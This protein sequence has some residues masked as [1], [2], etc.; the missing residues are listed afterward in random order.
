[1]RAMDINCDM[2]ESFGIYKLG[3]DEHI[4]KYISSANIACGYH[5]GDP[6]T[7]RKT[8]SLCLRNGVA[9]GAHPGF[10]DRE[11]F[12]RR[13]IHMSAQE[14]YDAVLY[15]VGALAGF[16]R[17][18]GERLRHVKPHGALYNM[19]AVRRDLADAIAKAVYHMDPGL[20]LYGLSGSELIAAGESA[21]LRT[22][23][24]VFSDRTYQRDGTLTPRTQPNALIDDR[25]AAADQV[26]QLLETGE[27]VAA[28]GHRVRVKADTVCIHGDGALAAQFAE[29]LYRT[30]TEQGIH[31]K[32]L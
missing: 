32:A 21:G 15:Q 19:A 23:N 18:E 29:Y 3:N 31:I 25:E 11:G 9:V 6:Q 8:V 14:V 30:F 13:A 10:P 20:I 22:A 12:G 27:L 24:E 16:V 5:A 4:V 26:I 28:D 17:A 7:M 2:G 1:M